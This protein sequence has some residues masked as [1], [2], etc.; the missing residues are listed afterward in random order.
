MPTDMQRWARE[1]NWTKGQFIAIQT[2]CRQIG[3]KKSTTLA[4]ANT[5][6]EITKKLGLLVDKFKERENMSKKV[7]RGAPLRN[8]YAKPFGGL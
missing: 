7:W 5:L 1:R 2:V 8:W 4:E 3:Y 6:S